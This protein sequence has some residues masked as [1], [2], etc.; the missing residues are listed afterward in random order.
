M[1]DGATPRAKRENRRAIPVTCALHQGA[2]NFANLVV[3]KQMRWDRK[4][5]RDVAE[6]VLDV[7]VTGTCVIIMDEG[8][9]RVLSG[10]LGDWLR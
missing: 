9:A 4:N 2:R 6:I 3:E 1:A 5:G 8:A 7:H 10:V